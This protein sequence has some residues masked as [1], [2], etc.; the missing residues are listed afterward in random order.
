MPSTRLLIT[1]S[2][3][4]AIALVATTAFSA[5]RGTPGTPRPGDPGRAP[6][7]YRR[8]GGS[9]AVGQG[10]ARAYVLLDRATNA[11]TEIGVALDERALEGLPTTG[12]GHHG[13]S[14]PVHQYVLPLPAAHTAPF[15]FVEVNWNPMGHEPDGVYQDVPHFDFHF[16]TVSKAERDRIVPTDPQYAARANAVPTG[17]YVP[18]FTLQLGPPGAKPADVA[19]PLMGVHWVDV[20]SAELQRLLGKP[21]AYRPFTA[22]FIHGSWNGRFHFWEPMV[23]RAHILAKKTT[24]DPAVR[25]EVIPISVPARYHVP[26]R[27]PTAYRITWDAKAREYRIALTGLAP[28]R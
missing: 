5:M 20:R 25:D 24:T 13:A 12:A 2:S 28:R 11:A 4:L 22:T 27:Y 26:G 14:G 21:D 17:D 8:D 9:A 10:R 16:Y 1:A 18:P 15:Q 19:V 7:T 3:G 6:A 23:T